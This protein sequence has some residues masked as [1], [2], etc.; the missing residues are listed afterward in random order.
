MRFSIP[1]LA[2]RRRGLVEAV[3][4]WDRSNTHSVAWVWFEDTAACRPASS[5]ESRVD[6]RVGQGRASTRCLTRCGL[7]MRLVEW[8]V[9]D[10]RHHED[11]NIIDHDLHRCT[12]TEVACLVISSHHHQLS[13][14]RYVCRVRAS[15]ARSTPRG[16]R[17]ATVLGS[18]GTAAHG[19][20]FLQLPC[21]RDC[22]LV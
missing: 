10:G 19:A 12:C 18:A 4:V 6:G 5:G 8:T 13:L 9:D 2:T 3:G 14:V 20:E 17:A 7:L 15:T 22:D 1:V 16:T 21:E 11:I